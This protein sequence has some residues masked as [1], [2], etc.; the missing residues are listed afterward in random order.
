M[1][2]LVLGATGMLGHDLIGTAPPGIALF[3]FSRAQ[4]DITVSNALAATVKDAKPDVIINAAAYT[5]VDKAES[6]PGRCYSVNLHA[7]GELGRIAVRNG[8]AVAHVSTDYVFDGEASQ[9]YTESSQTHP[10]NVY[11]ASKL[12]GEEALLRTGAT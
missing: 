6:D 5:A 7:V 2:V 1:R 10:M 9:P 3:P 8:A 12:A 11:G 4:L